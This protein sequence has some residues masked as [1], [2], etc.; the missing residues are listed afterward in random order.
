MFGYTTLKD[1]A[2]RDIALSESMIN[3]IEEWQAMMAGA[4]KWTADPVK[5]LR[6]EEGICR[7]FADAVLVEMETS[8][9]NERLDKIYQKGIIELNENFQ[10]GIGL[11]SLI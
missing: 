3:A 10:D 2:G 4:A 8:I 5:S 6:I 9:S 11:G 7:E 1:I